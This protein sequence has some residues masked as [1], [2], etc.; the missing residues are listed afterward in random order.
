[1]KKYNILIIKFISTILLAIVS[2]CAS[3]TSDIISTNY[4]FGSEH[5]RL[6]RN[7]C[8]VTD[9]TRMFQSYPTGHI[10]FKLKGFDKN[11]NFVDE[12]MLD[13]HSHLSRGIVV[14]D[15]KGGHFDADKA[16]DFACTEITTIQISD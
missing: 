10:T 3:T 2:G 4:E 5:I 1:M 11:N 6:H 16:G 7:G 13:C 15:C 12:I 8:S 14:S 9:V